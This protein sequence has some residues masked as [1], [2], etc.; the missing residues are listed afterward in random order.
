MLSRYDISVQYI[1]GKD[2]VAADALSRWAYPAS[3]GFADA[4]IHGS[5]KDEE[6]MEA[7]ILEEEAKG[8]ACR[9]LYAWEFEVE[10]S[11]HR[12]EAQVRGVTTRGGS[13]TGSAL[14]PEPTSTD[15]D[16]NEYV[17]DIT[18]PATTTV[19]SSDAGA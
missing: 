17:I 11:R 6:D 2:N 18:T 9:V 16:S 12:R 7:L 4:S 8:M 5:A 10:A 1:P 13:S 3:Q 19:S 15:S 14:Q